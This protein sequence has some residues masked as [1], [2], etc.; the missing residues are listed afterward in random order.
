MHPAYQPL[1]TLGYCNHKWAVLI[2]MQLFPQLTT[3]IT[4]RSNSETSMHARMYT[5]PSYLLRNIYYEG[6]FKKSL[7][8]I[9]FIRHLWNCNFR[10]P[11]IMSEKSVLQ[12]QNTFLN[13]EGKYRTIWQ[14]CR[15]WEQIYLFYGTIQECLGKYLSDW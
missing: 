9:S 11:V 5:V 13:N 8:F 7:I 12:K 3:F 6:Y 4:Y 14:V 10:K 1:C 15:Q 2:F